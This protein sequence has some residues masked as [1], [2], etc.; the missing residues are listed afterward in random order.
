MV[1]SH[2]FISGK[3]AMNDV[4]GGTISLQTTYPKGNQIHYQ[5]APVSTAMNLT[6]AVRLPAWSDSTS[7]TRNGNPAEY[8]V[9]NGYAYLQGSFTD[10]DDI[11]VTL[12]MSAKRVYSSMKVSANSGKVAFMRGPLVYCAEGNDNADNVIDLVIDQHSPVTEHPEIEHDG[13][14]TL[15]VGGWHMHDNGKLYSFDSPTSMPC[16]ITLIPYYT[17]GNRG[18]HSMRVW[19]PQT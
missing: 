18:L 17:W 9:A 6:L 3:F 2:L 13:M 14:P 1:Y 12:D 19:M 15:S 16:D 7:I 11:V 4:L 5:F 8:E 10:Q